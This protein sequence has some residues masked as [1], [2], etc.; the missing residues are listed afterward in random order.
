MFVSLFRDQR[1]PFH[2][3]R[4]VCVEFGG[5]PRG[6]VGRGRSLCTQG[7]RGLLGLLRARDSTRHSSARRRMGPT[8]IARTAGTV[9]GLFGLP[10][11]PAHQDT[12]SATTTGTKRSVLLVFA[13]VDVARP[14]LWHGG[15]RG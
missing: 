13:G 11:H 12:D 9:R 8:Q 6:R 2:V 14:S 10:T 5:C 1:N 3:S 4:R 7:V 15:C